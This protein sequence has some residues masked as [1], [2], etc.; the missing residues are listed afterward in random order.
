M[1]G[2][3]QKRIAHT[4]IHESILDQRRSSK[5][6]SP[7]ARLLIP[8]PDGP[9]HVSHAR[10]VGLIFE[11]APAGFRQPDRLGAKRC[12]RLIRRLLCI[13]FVLPPPR[14]AVV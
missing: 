14:I 5:E 9:P 6:A 13:T 8:A 3:R 2:C 7:Q 10:P 4:D 12:D 1:P 11:F